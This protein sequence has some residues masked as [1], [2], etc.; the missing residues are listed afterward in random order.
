MYNCEFCEQLFTNKSL[1]KLHLLKD[2]EI[3]A[4][5]RVNDQR[6]KLM[7]DIKKLKSTEERQKKKHYCR[8]ICLI[9]HSRFKYV[10]SKAEMFSGNLVAINEEYVRKSFASRNEDFT[11]NATFNNPGLQENINVISASIHQN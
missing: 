8:S 10:R 9:D 11:V 5:N 7:Q 3:L 4:N 6:L 1:F 2:H